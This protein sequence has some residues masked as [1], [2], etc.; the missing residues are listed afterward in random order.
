MQEEGELRK[1]VRIEPFKMW[2]FYNLDF[3]KRFDITSL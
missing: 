1:W 3:L 2:E